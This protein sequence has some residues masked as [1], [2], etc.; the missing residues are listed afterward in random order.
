MLK[1][2]K[3]SSAA[4]L[5][6]LLFA[7]YSPVHSLAQSISTNGFTVIASP[8]TPVSGGAVTVSWTAPS[9]H[10][11][12]DWIGLFLVGQPSAGNTIVMYKYVPGGTSG[13]MTFNVPNVM[14]PHTYEFRY[15]LNNGFTKTATSNDSAKF[16]TC[17]PIWLKCC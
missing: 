8:A 12:Q 11:S 16:L 6:P 7:L 9:T 2:F 5:I 15:F 13:L 1:L 10:S 3:T 17:M 4:I 14:T